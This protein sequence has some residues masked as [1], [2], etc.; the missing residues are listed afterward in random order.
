MSP[1]AWIAVGAGFTAILGAALAGTHFLV[2]APLEAERAKA[3]AKAAEAV[4]ARGDAE[5]RLQHERENR[6]GLD[7]RHQ[8]L[9]QDFANLRRGETG[10]FLKHEIE[11][12][13]DR[14]MEVLGVTEGSILVPD[15]APGAS[16]FV[17][18]V[19]QGPAAPRIRSAKPPR[20]SIVGR[21]FSTGTPYNTVNAHH[22]SNF[23]SGIDEK[24][25]HLT[26]TMLTVPLISAGRVVGVA[27]FLNK[28]GGFDEV[29][30][31]RAVEFADD[32]APLVRDFV[33]KRENFL[34]L[35]TAGASRER[36][37]T[38]AFCDLTRSSVLLKEMNAPSAIDCI[39][40]YFEQQ[41]EIAW[42]FGATVD[43]YL[44]DGA[45]LCFNVP[46][47]IYDDDH[48]VRAVEAAL[49]MQEQFDLL[50]SDWLGQGLPVGGIYNRIGLA[51]GRVVETKIGHSRSPQNTL[52]GEPVNEAA[53]LC[54][55]ADR[56][57]DVIVVSEAL[58]AK[59]GQ[60]FA[61]AE[62][63]ASSRHGPSFELTRA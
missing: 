46:R 23:F 48:S 37:A 22:D 54:G 41:C 5:R 31:A 25:E 33:R 24:G 61:L 21:V 13:L 30:E 11:G 32:L 28:A 60:R 43:K 15:P 27:Q 62:S 9:Q 57:R 50:R 17:F 18:L 19:A 14:A 58:A 40:E 4:A 56:G 49:R 55:L 59:L 36:E 3:E 29:D 51:T 6:V 26:R 8:S 38:I 1:D 2:R 47:P 53:N 12:R 7:S 34:L 44:G 39:N 42:S 52:I 35:G 10:V 63:S 20:G 16:N 45:M